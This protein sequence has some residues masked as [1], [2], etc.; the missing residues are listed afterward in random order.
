MKKSGV[1]GKFLGLFLISLIFVSLMIV[2]VAAQ[3]APAAPATDDGFIES[4]AEVVTDGIELVKKTGEPLF[5]A[6]LGATAS[7][8]NLFVKILVFLLI[9]LV[10]YAV[11]DRVGPFKEK[12][13]VQLGI[14]LVFAILGVRFIPEDLLVAL[15][16]PSSAL[17]GVLV[18]GIPFLIFGYILYT[19]V[20]SSI[21]R[22]I[23][24]AAFS[25]FLIVLFFYN[26]AATEGA[27]KAW[28]WIYPVLFVVC[29]IALWY[30]GTVARWR[31]KYYAQRSRSQIDLAS[32]SANVK[33]YE[34]LKA[35]FRNMS[36]DNANYEVTKKRLEEL[37]KQVAS[38]GTDL[39]S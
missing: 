15:L 16:I 22:R 9:I 24:W 30:D 6:L 29:W 31:G 19:S 8:E 27:L 25:A 7:G 5:N 23:G 37:K 11:L 32:Y 20:E 38:S 4:S 1:E 35:S 39:S 36:P 34:S 3:V 17:V 18:V 10:V 33:D 28:H 21:A 14:G 26:V 12:T 2:G 13:W